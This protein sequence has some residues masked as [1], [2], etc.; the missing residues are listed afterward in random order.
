MGGGYYYLEQQAPAD[1]FDDGDTITATAPGDVFPS[2]GLTASGVAPIALELDGTGADE[3]RLVDGDDVTLSWG[4]AD[5]DTRVRLWLPSPNN[6]HGLPSNFVIECEGPDT[7]SLVIPQ[8]I[9]EAFPANP[10]AEICVGHDCPLSWFM[11]Y[12]ADTQTT[13]AGD[14]RLEVASS[15]SF[16]L[17]H[18]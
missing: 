2:F 14:I 15:A 17:V 7:G 11:R 18:E 8:A 10:R 1:L 3:L 6:G 12:S 4:A 16:F 5:P 13:T 9:V